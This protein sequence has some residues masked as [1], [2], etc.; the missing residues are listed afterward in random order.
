MAAIHP[1]N[2]GIRLPNGVRVA[3]TPHASRGGNPYPPEV[4]EQVL[5]MYQTGGIESLQTPHLNQLRLQRKFPH[6]EKQ[7]LC[8]FITRRRGCGCGPQLRCR[9]RSSW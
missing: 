6:K 8:F 2:D 1:G 4:R 7:S 9:R 3:T 5:L